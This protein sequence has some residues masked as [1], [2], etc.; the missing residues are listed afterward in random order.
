MAELKVTINQT[1]PT[2]TNHERPEII[3]HIKD[4]TMASRLDF[5]SDPNLL[6]CRNEFVHLELGRKI[7]ED[8]D[9][10]LLSVSYEN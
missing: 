3:S 4:K 1:W 6:N 10:P 5:D 2:R 8:P 9:N 7:D